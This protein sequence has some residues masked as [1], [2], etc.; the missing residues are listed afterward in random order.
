[1]DRRQSFDRWFKSQR[2]QYLRYH[3]R[4]KKKNLQKTKAGKSFLEFAKNLPF[5]KVNEANGLS[6]PAI[7]EKIPYN[8]SFVKMILK[9]DADIKSGKTKTIT[10]NPDDI[11]GNLNLK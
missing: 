10:V 1:M 7:K 6:K 5:V 2:L 8:P 4:I 9:R 11:W 3:S